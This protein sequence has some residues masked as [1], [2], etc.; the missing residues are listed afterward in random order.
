M[1]FYI[2][3]V[4]VLL[5]AL[6]LSTK[7]NVIGASS[8]NVVS[9]KTIP[10]TNSFSNTIPTITVR[11][12]PTM[13]ERTLVYKEP[14]N[15]FRFYPFSTTVVDIPEDIQTALINC[16]T[17]ADKPL[18]ASVCDKNST[19]YGKYKNFTLYSFIFHTFISDP[20]GTC[21]VY[22][23][24]ANEPNP[25][26]NYVVTNFCNP[27]VSTIIKNTQTTLGVGPSQHTTSK[28]PPSIITSTSSTKIPP[29][30]T[31]SSVVTSTSSTK[32]LPVNNV[33]EKETATL[34]VKRSS[35]PISM[36]DNHQCVGQWAQCGGM[37][38]KGPT[39]CESG[40]RCHKINKF[41]FQCI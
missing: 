15:N 14:P 26:A 22:T 5:L 4:G 35:T 29:S 9:S 21:G 25:T 6:V 38:F 19:C 41:F 28:I 3:S 40:Y 8:T 17:T 37:G 33:T 12:S 24:R 32:Y 2:K 23:R 16:D 11:S 30:I 36:N 1:K 7:V 20:S 27:T 31:T 39:C 18:P 10:T 13:V 34:I